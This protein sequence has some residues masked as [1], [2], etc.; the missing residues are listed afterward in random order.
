MSAVHYCDRCG[1]IIAERRHFGRLKR[2]EGR[3]TIEVHVAV[4]N[5]WNKGDV[6]H[7]CVAHVAM[8]GE[9]VAS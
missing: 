5:T 1:G 3:V 4:D 2:R 8:H 9:D 6:C 7:D